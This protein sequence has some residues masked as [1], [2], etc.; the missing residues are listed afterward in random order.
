MT[1]GKTT[2]LTRRTFVG[3]VMPLLFSMLSRLII[4]LLPRRKHLLISWLQSHLQWFWSPKSKVSVSIVSPPICHEVMG[5]DVMI[6][7]FWMF[8]FKPVFSFSSFTFIKRLFSSSLSTIRLVSSAY[9][10]LL[11]FLLAILIPDISQYVY[12]FTINGLLDCFYFLTIMNN[13]QVQIFMYRYV[14]WS[15]VHTHEYVCWVVW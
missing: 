10:R 1:T 2:A 4:A 13:I 14:F 8:S 3:K 11:I 6:L 9:L 12:L 5:P 15:W 7:V